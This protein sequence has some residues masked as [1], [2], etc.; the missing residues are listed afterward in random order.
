MSL[1]KPHPIWSS[2]GSNPFECHKAVIASRMLSGRYLTD[3]L[4]RHWTENKS[5]FCL[6]PAC[7]S[8][9]A[10]G[11]LEHLLLFCPSLNNTRERLLELVSSVCLEDESISTILKSVFSSP[12][13]E[14]PMQFLL[15]CSTMP[16]VIQAAQGT[17]NHVRDRLLYLGRTWCYNIHRERMTQLGLLKFRWMNTNHNIIILRAMLVES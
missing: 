4:Q 17:R 8:S 6:L 7:E 9:D 12:D 1:T 3:K 5:G 10:D 14:V 16:A 2:C 13:P 15:D 11:T